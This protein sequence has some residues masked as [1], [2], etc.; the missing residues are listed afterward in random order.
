MMTTEANKVSDLRDNP[1]G[2]LLRELKSM[3]LKNMCLNNIY[4]KILIKYRARMLILPR[5]PIE[6]FRTHVAKPLSEALLKC[7]IY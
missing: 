4:E 7:E 2:F 3:E 5:N 1:Q 6:P